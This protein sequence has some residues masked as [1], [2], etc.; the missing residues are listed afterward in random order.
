MSKEVCIHGVDLDI[1]EENKTITCQ[2][3]S[4]FSI[5]TL[6]H[7]ASEIHPLYQESYLRRE[8]TKNEESSV[9]S[10]QESE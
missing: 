10:L 1:E 6:Y 9:P 5:E 3:P 2:K 8:R 4:F 7:G